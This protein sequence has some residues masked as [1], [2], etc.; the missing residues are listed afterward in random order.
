MSLFW[1]EIIIV[2]TKSR[3][4]SHFDSK[5][6]SGKLWKTVKNRGM[7]LFQPGRLRRGVISGDGNRSVTAVPLAPPLGFPAKQRLR[8]VVL[9][10]L[11]KVEIS[12][13]N[14]GFALFWMFWR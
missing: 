7:A 4:Y 12:G 6:P 3:E 2:F 8:A 1:P 14:S 5:N 9:A 10:Q 13:Q 11:V